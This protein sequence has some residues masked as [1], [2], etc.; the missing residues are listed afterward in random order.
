MIL[1]TV[2]FTVRVAPLAPL[3]LIGYVPA[4]IGPFVV[5]ASYFNQPL[6]IDALP[7]A[8]VPTISEI[9]SPISARIV[10]PTIM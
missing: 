10:F 3:T 2:M 7:A 5:D 6:A 1:L 4:F 8:G 9:E